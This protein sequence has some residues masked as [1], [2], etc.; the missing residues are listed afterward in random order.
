MIR[1]TTLA[2]A[3]LIAA[4]PAFAQSSMPHSSMPMDH[5]KMP[6]G[7][8]DASHMNTLHVAHGWARAT[9]GMARNGAAYMTLHN[10]GKTD[11]KLIDAA[12][13]VAARTEIHTHIMDGTV[14]KMRKVEGGVAFA[15]GKEVTF[16]PGGLHIMFLGLKAPLK[17][18]STFPVTLTFEKAGKKT[19]EIKVQKVG[20]MMP[21][22]GH[23]EGMGTG[24]HHG[25]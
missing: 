23:K 5:G 13:D 22:D 12:S 16:K 25:H 21:M 8:H 11:D 10:M 3:A 19:V 4:G 17:E 1:M 7:G 9:P 14:M 18:G 15:S 6:M 20:A 24:M 2:C